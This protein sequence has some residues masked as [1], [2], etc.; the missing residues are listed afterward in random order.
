[1]PSPGSAPNTG[2]SGTKRTI[3]HQTANRKTNEQPR[4]VG[5]VRTLRSRKLYLTSHAC[6]LRPQREL[7][8]AP[9]PQRGDASSARPGGKRAR[10]PP[11]PTRIASDPSQTASVNTSKES[12]DHV[13]PS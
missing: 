8:G 12:C 4:S 1:M 7:T 9:Q 2:L 5:S 11:G 13:Q 3:D 10:A 6:V